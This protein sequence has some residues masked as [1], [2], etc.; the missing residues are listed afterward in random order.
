MQHISR[1]QQL[2]YHLCFI[3]QTRAHSE[4]LLPMFFWEPIILCTVLVLRMCLCEAAAF[5]VELLF[6]VCE[7]LHV[8]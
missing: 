3:H 6:S 2:P 7:F 8:S 5:T 1:L 4:L